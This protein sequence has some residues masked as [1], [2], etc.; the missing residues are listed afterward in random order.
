MKQRD[1]NKKK[2]DIKRTAKKE[3][4][5]HLDVCI[6]LSRDVSERN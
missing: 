6:I 3:K 5:S 2:T 4:K 1:H